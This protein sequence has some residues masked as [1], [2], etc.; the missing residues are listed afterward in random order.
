MMSVSLKPIV[1]KY[2]IHKLLHLK[3]ILSES[4]NLTLHPTSPYRKFFSSI[5]KRKN[6][7]ALLYISEPVASYLGDSSFQYWTAVMVKQVFMTPRQQCED[8]ANF[9]LL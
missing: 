5:T 3:E 8:L 4:S 2:R 9:F 6:N 1:E 7:Q